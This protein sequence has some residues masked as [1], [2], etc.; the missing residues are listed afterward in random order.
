MEA[1]SS[2]GD[3]TL[4]FIQ[5]KSPTRFVVSQT[6]QTKSRAKTCTLDTLKN[7][8]VLITTEPAP[9]AP[10]T[11]LPPVAETGRPGGGR[12]GPRGPSLLDILIVGR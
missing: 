6:V 10:G 9:I 7:Q 5:E 1:F 8:I 4:T 11:V 2:Q 12:G 3:G